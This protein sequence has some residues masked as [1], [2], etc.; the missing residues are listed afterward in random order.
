MKNNKQYTLQE[1]AK[2]L[3]E[4]FMLPIDAYHKYPMCFDTA[5]QCA[6][7]CVDNERDL[8]INLVSA[9]ELSTVLGTHLIDEL[10]NMKEEIEML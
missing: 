5:K 9:N 7:I 10:N 8:I 4:T 6:L 3:V 2:L 1:R